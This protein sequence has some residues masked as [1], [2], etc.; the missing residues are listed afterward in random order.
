ML[1]PSASIDGYL[2]IADTPKCGHIL[3]YFFGFGCGFC[4]L[5]A[6]FP[7]PLH[8]FWIGGILSLFITISLVDAHYRL[9]SPTL[10]LWLC[11]LGLLGAWQGLTPL[12]LA[13]SLQSAV[14]FFL[15]F[16]G[17]YWLA[18]WYYRRE[19]LGRGDYWLMLGIGSLLPIESFPVV[20]CI[21]C[22]LGILFF[23]V[24]KRLRPTE[25]YLPF[26]PFLCVATLVVWSQII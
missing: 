9:I 22:G 24:S 2:A 8:A 21:A 3:L 1:F 12:P 18:K 26:A 23:A 17:L 25:E 14:I 5:Y 4:L 19:A 15:I 16:Y 11:A 13:L 20:L 6:Y 10:C 7:Q